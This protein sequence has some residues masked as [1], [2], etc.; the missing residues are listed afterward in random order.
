MD[1]GAPGSQSVLTVNQSQGVQNTSSRVCDRCILLVPPDTKESL[2][3]AFTL[4]GKSSVIVFPEC[5]VLVIDI[6]TA[7]A[8]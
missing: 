2:A 1:S 7:Q 8:I 4:G 6:D 5:T 3:N